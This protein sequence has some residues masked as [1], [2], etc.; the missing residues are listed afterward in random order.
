MVRERARGSKLEEVYKRKKGRIT[1][2]TQHTLTMKEIGKSTAQTFSKREIAKPQQLAQQSSQSKHT[3]SPQQKKDTKQIK[4]NE[5]QNT[6]KRREKKIP[7]EF[8]RLANWRELLESEDEEEIDKRRNERKQ[9]NQPKTPIKATVNWEKPQL[10]KEEPE[11]ENETNS[12]TSN[13]RPKR[14]RITPNYYGNPVMICGIENTNEEGEREVIT[15]SS[16][17]N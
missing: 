14:N 13:E 2:E 5:Q 16:D 12:N 17:E 3:N 10:T 6:K 15:I 9:T 1:G 8:K 4:T 7:T 11:S